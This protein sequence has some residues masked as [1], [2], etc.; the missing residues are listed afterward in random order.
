[1]I[2]SLDHLNVHVERIENIA[3]MRVEGALTSF[4]HNKFLDEVKFANRKGGLIIDME[5]L[6]VVSSTGIEA[7]RK[8]VDLSYVSGNKIVLL[9]LS[10]H[11]KQ[12]LTM[13]GYLKI[14]V[15]APNEEL[16]M[17]MASKS[18]K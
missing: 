11:V 17:K 1:M 4:T 5:E 3:V 7:M 14:F 12:V 10:I 15:V 8:M 16:A 9:N 18:G 6:M 2:K 13:M